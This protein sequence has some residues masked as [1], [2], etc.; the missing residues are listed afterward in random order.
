MQ[1]KQHKL[2]PTLVTEIEGFLTPEQSAD[3]L[4][5][6]LS[7]NKLTKPHTAIIGGGESFHTKESEF[8]PAVTDNVKSCCDLEEKIKNE[9]YNYCQTTGYISVAKLQNS[10]FNIQDVGSELL[11][12]AHPGAIVSGAL[13]VN[14]DDRSSPLTVYNPNPMM[15]FSYITDRTDSTYEW[16]T[17][18]PSVGSL[19]LFPSWLKHGSNRVQNNTPNRM[20]ISFNA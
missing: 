2:F 13:Y 8:L 9:V 19:I 14:V 16:F 1:I 4:A 3:L 17:F 5:Y 20:V 10:W 18:N 11:E 12:H 6:G 15:S 7:L